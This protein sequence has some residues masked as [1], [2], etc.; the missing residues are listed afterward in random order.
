MTIDEMR[1]KRIEMGLTYA[2]LSK[3]SGVPVPTIQKLFHGE[4]KAPRYDTLRALEKVFLQPSMV[5]EPRVPYG[6]TN[7]GGTHSGGVHSGSTGHLY[8]RQ[9]HY[10][11]DDY[12]SLPDDQRVEL[13]DGVFY[14]M[15]SPAGLHQLI[16]GEVYRQISNFLLERSASC[17]ALISPL[18]VQLDEDDRTMVQ[19]DVLILCDRDK[20]KKGRVFGAPDFV[21]E[22]LSPSTGRKDSFLKLHKYANAGVRE[23]WIIDPYREKLLVYYFEEG[24]IPV[25]SGLDSLVPI[26]LYEGELMIDP[27]HILRWIREFA[28]SDEQ[29]PDTP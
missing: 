2:M 3:R 21:L 8:P 29:D 26:R 4:T 22:V 27:V 10:T 9:G 16:A 18:D 14:D 13:I 11:L 5:M 1:Q 28:S 25:I 17:M 12:F 15:A 20:L 7:S 24:D 6:G 23:Y 19:P